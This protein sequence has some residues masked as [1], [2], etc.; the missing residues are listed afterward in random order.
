MFPWLGSRPIRSITAPELLTCLRRIEARGA[1]D[2]V[3]RA[4][5]NFGQVFRYAVATGRADRDPSGDL[6]GALAPALHVHYPTITE[7]SCIG[8]LLRAIDG[9]QGSLVVRCA[10]RLAPLVFV[11][12]GELRGAEWGE[13]DISQA[14]WRIRAQRMKAR[15]Q[16]LVPLARQSLVVLE[17]LRP[18]TGDGKYLFPSI[19]NPSKPMSENTINVA[20]RAMGYSHS[21]MT[22]HG[23]R[24][25]ASTL[26]NESG[27]W[28]SDVIE[29]QLAHGERD[30]VRAAY[31]YAKHL[32][33][34]RRMM[35]SWADQ[36]DKLKANGQKCSSVS[37]QATRSVRSLSS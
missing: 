11:R 32:L 29:R 17:E 1:L 9:Y 34:R 13:F 22:G 7:P 21:Q 23:F 5:Q 28:N 15:V 18:L 37:S 31:N 24:S 19:R 36:L 26:L 6:R 35:Q 25:M 8:E 10:L 33:A 16:H 14:E 27:K 2:T 4:L 20:L 30:E 12:P 3:H